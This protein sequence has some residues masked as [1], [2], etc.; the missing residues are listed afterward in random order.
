VVHTGSISR[1]PLDREG[2]CEGPLPEAVR[3]TGGETV[4]LFVGSGFAR[5]GVGTIAP[6]REAPGGR[7]CAAFRVVLVAGGPVGARPVGRTR[8]GSALFTGPVAGADDLFLG[9]D[10]FLFP[11]VYEPFSNACLEAM[12]AGLPSSPLS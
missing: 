6:R 10:A 12:A 2:R 8:L 9:A 4:F 1:V 5:K 11:T 3:N 7:G